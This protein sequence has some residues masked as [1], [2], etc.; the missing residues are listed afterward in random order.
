MTKPGPVGSVRST[1]RRG[2]LLGRR[3][4]GTLRHR[5][6]GIVIHPRQE[7]TIR[8]GNRS[9][10]TMALRVSL[11]LTMLTLASSTAWAA[12]GTLVVFGD[13][14]ENGFDHNATVYSGGMSLE[15]S[16]VHSGTTAATVV[17]QNFNGAAWLA[18]MTYSTL[19]DYDTISFWLYDG[20]G[21]VGPQDL[22]FL[23]YNSDDAIVGKVN[24]VDVYGAVLP[25]NVW[26]NLLVPL[27]GLSNPSSVPDQTH[28]NTLVIRTYTTNSSQRFFI[29]DVQLIGADIFKD[30]FESPQP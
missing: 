16:L 27:N 29:D 19:S 1:R 5:A 17:A 4:P 9:E 6:F 30:G 24:L 22:A 26:I 15:Q 28:F 23:L 8:P 11:L 21:G 18:P 12:S 3:Y 13:A 7:S 14:D 25:Q 10:M 20:F 2:R